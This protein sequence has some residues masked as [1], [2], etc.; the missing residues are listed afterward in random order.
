MSV[1]CMAFQPPKILISCIVYSDCIKKAFCSKFW[2]YCNNAWMFS[3]LNNSFQSRTSYF[4]SQ[5]IKTLK[6]W[7]LKINYTAYS[8]C[9]APIQC[10]NLFNYFFL[11]YK[12]R[13]LK[14]LIHSLINKKIIWNKM[15]HFCSNNKKY[16]IWQIY[17]MCL[18]I[19]H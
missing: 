5:R 16:F 10:K 19:L 2:S 3:M 15:I 17:K 11:V 7:D 4:F 13:L 6:L 8:I 1:A 14:Y 18:I 12:R 9:M